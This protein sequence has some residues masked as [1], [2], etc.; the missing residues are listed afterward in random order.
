MMIHWAHP[1]SLVCF[2]GA[3]PLAASE[4]PVLFA[5]GFNDGAHEWLTTGGEWA[6]RDGAFH[7]R[8]QDPGRNAMAM[9]ADCAEIDG[10]VIEARVLMGERLAS[11][12]WA[13]AGI[14]LFQGPDDF[15]VLAL[16]EDARGARSVDFIECRHRRWQAQ[17][18]EGAGLREILQEGG[19]GD[20]HRDAAHTLRI[21]LDDRGITGTVVGPD[22]TTLVARRFEF[23][24]ADAVRS[25]QPALLTRGCASVFDDLRVTSPLPGGMRRKEIAAARGPAGAAAVLKDGFPGADPGLV[26]L[27]VGALREAGF[28]V[29][30]LSGEQACDTAV[31]HPH[32]FNLYAVPGAASYPRDGLPALSAY[33]RHGGDVLFVGGPAFTNLLARVDGTWLDRAAFDARLSALPAGKILFDGDATGPAWKLS[34][35]AKNCDATLQQT[36]DGDA[37][38]LRYE[39]ANLDGWAMFGCQPATPIFLPGHDAV[40]FRAKA[41]VGSPP[42]TI[43]LIEKDGSRWMAAV[44]MPPDWTRRAVP[45]TSF[46]YWKDS[47]TAKRRG[48]ARDRC[49]PAAVVRLQIGLANAIAQASPGRH[50]LWIDDFGTAKNV[51]GV[52][53][54]PGAPEMPIFETVS[55][56]YKTYPLADVRALRS[57]AGVQLPACDLPAPLSGSAFAPVR[58]PGAAGSGTGRPWRFLPL[59]DAFDA[60][61]HRLGS[62]AWLVANVAPPYRGCVMGTIGIDGADLSNGTGGR[63]LIGAIA[64]RMKAGLFLTEAGASRFTCR[65]GEALEVGARV[66]NCGDAVT[67]TTVRIEIAGPGK[68]L[69]CETAG[70][71]LPPSGTRTVRFPWRAPED[72]AATLSVRTELTR[73]GV[74]VD[75]AAHDLSIEPD[76]VPVREDFIMVRG[77]DF[78]L[79]GKPWHPIGANYWP[80]Y[81]AGLEPDQYAGGWLDPKFYDPALIEDDLSLMRDLGM[82]LVSIQL[83]TPEEIPNLRDFL[84]RCGAHGIWVNGFLRTA[85][86]M[87]FDEAATRAFI[88]KAGLRDN[89]TLFA[90][91]TIWEAGNHLFKSPQR[92]ARDIDWRRWII[93]RY[94]SLESAEKDWGMAAPSEGGKVTAPSDKQ[95]QEDGPWRA[96]VAAY[97][98]FMDDITSRRWNDASRALRAIDPNHLVSFRQGNTL[99]YDFALTGPVK[100]IDFISPEGYAIPHTEDG[101]DASGFITRYVRFTTAGKPVYWAEFGKS[102][103]NQVGMAVDPTMVGVQADYHELFHRMVIE[104]GA[105]GLAPWWWPGGYRVNERS[106]YGIIN[107]DGT[108]RPSA[109]LFRKY[110]PRLQAAGTDRAP[111]KWFQF[112]RDAHPGGYW[113]IVFH[114]GAASYRKARQAGAL[115]GIRTDA[116]GT[117]S[118]NVPLTAVGNTVY[119]GSNPPKYLNAE[120][121]ALVVCD[122]RG[123]WVSIGPDGAEV[124]VRRGQP[125]RAKASV[126]NLGEAL[127]L[128]PENHRGPGGVYLSSRKGEIRFQQPVARDIPRFGDADFGEFVLCRAPEHPALVTLEMTALDRAWFGEQRAVRLIPE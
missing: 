70:L 73:D 111:D 4:N 78:V 127:W 61:G 87:A 45:V 116:T 15:W 60:K 81:A 35:K 82:N 18:D 65:P 85:S 34:A 17:R 16:N 83:G 86:P 39:V 74:T 30:T 6:A 90:Y 110:G 91:D 5:D 121:N 66:L 14:A 28:G 103:W 8:E 118:G 50:V 125:V 29:S 115:L 114:E 75:S 22:G 11:T 107:P 84:R 43:E 44:P 53:T 67:A 102:I 54:G 99:F 77:G 12:G 117:H 113:Y 94:G 7:G 93:Q 108:P 112:D 95:M 48:G 1:F 76:R 58:R 92:K 56:S 23:G 97:R 20:W 41:P 27:V 122:A 3:S 51:I 88:E 13:L 2:L 71:N 26:D 101:Y 109:E 124:R 21:A 33:A 96:M 123:Q 52:F 120:F 104:A 59:M 46:E 106:D 98:R 38:C 119:N 72:A 62:A 10:G 31:L 42:L 19:R 36:T 24:A 128:A 80:L 25:G 55:P 63:A 40:C 68:I 37:K 69:F 49:N 79:R 126:G 57:P 9:P 100:H 105:N 47:P 32:T 64:R 89:P